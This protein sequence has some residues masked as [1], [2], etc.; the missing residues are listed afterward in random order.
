MRQNVDQ[1]TI[2]V[3]RKSCKQ[4]FEECDKTNKYSGLPSMPGLSSQP[5]I[6]LQ[7]LENFSHSLD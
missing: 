4:P 5:G 1:S 7:D 3:L 6:N 2:L